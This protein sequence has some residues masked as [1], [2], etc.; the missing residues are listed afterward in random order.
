MNILNIAKIGGVSETVVF[1]KFNLYVYRID[2]MF[3][4]LIYTGF[5]FSLLTTYI[6]RSA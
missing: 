6:L 3:K 2:K 1:T 4:Y 5:K